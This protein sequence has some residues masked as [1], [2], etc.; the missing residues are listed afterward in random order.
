[1][2]PVKRLSL[3]EI[4]Q[5][6]Y[7]QFQE[8]VPHVLPVSSL[9]VPPIDHDKHPTRINLNDMQLDMSEDMEED[10][11]ALE[12]KVKPEQKQEGKERKFVFIR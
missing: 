1:M 12:E 4:L 11:E 9:A 10:Q 8:G 5:H 7:M 6:K 2:D 3:E